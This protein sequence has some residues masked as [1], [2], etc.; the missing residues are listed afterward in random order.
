LDLPPEHLGQQVVACAELARLAGPG[1]GLVQL[2]EPVVGLSEQRRRAGQVASLPK[3][4]VEPA[5]LRAELHCRGI[6]ACEE[7]ELDEVEGEGPRKND[8]S[9][10][11]GL[12]RPLHG[13]DRAPLLEATEQGERLSPCGRYR[14]LSALLLGVYPGEGVAGGGPACE[15][16]FG[17]RPQEL[18]G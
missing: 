16:S 3:L 8:A 7:L 15:A 13:E 2:P 6:V 10:A 14:F 18:V 5:A 4:C 9:T 1:L 17:A 12:R 11:L